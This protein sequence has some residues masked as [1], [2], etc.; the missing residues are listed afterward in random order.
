LKQHV[1][2]LGKELFFDSQ[3][4]WQ[5]FPDPLMHVRPIFKR[6]EALDGP[7]H[8]PAQLVNELESS[9]EGCCWL[10]DR[11]G[12]LKRKLH[13]PPPSNAWHAF[14]KF[15]CIRLLSAQPLDV[16]DDTTCDLL[17]VFLASH[18]IHPA[19]K[20]P[21]A[22]LRCEVHEDQYPALKRRLAALDIER[23]RP[24]SM[25][26][27]R[28]R[29]DDLITRNV[30]RLQY[31]ASAHSLRDEADAAERSRRLAFDPGEAA[32]R[33]RRYEDMA[34]RRMTRA[35]EDLANLRHSGLMGEVEESG[36]ATAAPE[37]QGTAQGPP[38]ELVSIMETTTVVAPDQSVSIVAVAD[39]GTGAQGPPDEM[40]SMAATTVQGLPDEPVS[41][42]A[43]L[44]PGITAADSP[45]EMGS[46]AA[47]HESSTAVPDARLPVT[48]N[49]WTHIATLLLACFCWIIARGHEPASFPL[50]CPPHSSPAALETRPQWTADGPPSAGSQP[51]LLRRAPGNFAPLAPLGRGP[52]RMSGV[53][54]SDGLRC[55]TINSS[56]NSSHAHAKQSQG[57][58]CRLCRH[59]GTPIAAR[60]PGV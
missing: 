56:R 1:I 25:E 33:V 59:P 21:F 17:T 30:D 39:F 57:N 44:Q 45:A 41:I 49:R 24:V 55:R 16:L 52:D 43:A 32:E 8:S 48:G 29:L 26:A 46:T 47:A 5:L 34:T 10:L 19:Q 27:A 38:G 4:L 11:W 20:S 36:S 58:L 35:C 7:T 54:G 42:I 3:D 31:L 22:E 28:K 14:D 60:S 51:I 23:H 50:G 9:Y 40:V 37:S 15:K 13:N 6:E 18:E 53:R 2:A 12:E